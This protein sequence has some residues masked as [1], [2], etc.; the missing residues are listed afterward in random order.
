MAFHAVP[1]KKED[2]CILIRDAILGRK[3]RIIAEKGESFGDRSYSGTFRFS[4]CP[5]RK[6]IVKSIINWAL[7]NSLN[8]Y[9]RHSDWH[10]LTGY[11]TKMPI[12][13]YDSL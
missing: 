8:A 4:V 3:G 9:D 12:Y 13:F 11:A 6:T 5:Y 10:N 2:I 7:P 1:R